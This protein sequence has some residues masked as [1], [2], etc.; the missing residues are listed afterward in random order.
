MSQN[1]S[2]ISFY[3]KDRSPIETSKNRHC[4]Q[5]MKMELTE[6]T[7]PF[8]IHIL[9]LSINYIYIIFLSFFLFLSV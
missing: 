9:Y 4:T 2:S 1:K 6:I 7:T 8:L 3:K 5:N